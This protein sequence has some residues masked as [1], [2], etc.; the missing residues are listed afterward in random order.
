MPPDEHRE[1]LDDLERLRRRVAELEGAHLQVRLDAAWTDDSYL[2]RALLDYLPDSIYFKDCES[3]FLRINRALADRFG[4]V[5]PADAIGK[6]DA[7]FFSSEHAEQALADEQELLRSGRPMMYKEEKETWPDGRITWVATTKI[8][9]HDEHGELVG[10][11][12]ISRDITRRRRAEEQLRE[13]KAAAEAASRAKSEFLANMSHEIRT[14]MNAIIGMTELVLGTH[15][16]NEQREYLAMVLESG[17]SLLAIINDILD[18]SKVEAGRLELER[19]P[20][21]LRE[22]LGDTMKSLALRAHDQGLE[23]ACEIRSHVPDA[24][25]GDPVRLRQVVVNLVGNAIKF[26][27]RGEVV[28]RVDPHEYAEPSPDEVVLRFTISDTGVGIP[29]E[30]LQAI[31]DAFEQ[32]DS[33]VTRKYGGTG[34]GLAI[35]TRLV[36]LMG[37]VINVRSELD[38]GSTFEFTACFGLAPE[39]IPVPPPERRVIIRGTPVLVVDDNETNRRILNEMLTNWGL[40]PAVA[41]GAATALEMLRQREETG[42]PFRLV[43]TDCHM[44]GIDGFTLVEEIKRLD[45]DKN[46]VVMMLTSGDQ[47]GNIAR[48]EELGVAAYLLKPVKQSELFDAI[49]LAL[50]VT[51]AEDEQ[52]VTHDEVVRLG[53]LT[54]LL[55]EDSLVNQKLALGLLERHGHRVVVASNGK[56]AVGAYA[57]Q[58]F[59]LVLMDVQMPEMDGLEATQA[60]RHIEKQ[61]GRRTPIAAM[62]AHAM[63][64]DRQRCLDAGMD[65]YIA[66]P[67][68]AK[69]LFETIGKLVGERA[70][71]AP[72]LEEG[73]ADSA[74][75]WSEALAA[76]GDDR[77]LLQ[78]L[79]DAFLVESPQR[80]CGIEAAIAARDG[81]DL[82]RQAHSLKSAIQFF[83]VEGAA[84]LACSLEDAGREQN[85]DAASELLS[86]LRVELKELNTGLA[87]RSESM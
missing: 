30:K 54:I 87:A 31:F 49:A 22:S 76:V 1:L 51:G 70:A 69:V 39:E 2:L 3:R 77:E 55:A 8:P 78:E 14:P 56:E 28:V 18:F 35:S 32:A 50:G 67:V 64:G 46:P 33:S 79:I 24:L 62:T 25:L 15:L 7:D 4:L 63:Q 66:K 80:M 74:I 71:V 60:I 75:K 86:L 29:A 45:S 40:R 9:L 41:A 42:D 26:T 73:R 84:D 11:F 17:E 21:S 37:G 43:L 59:D 61:S 6:S 23:L 13:A 12:G 47:P 57:S 44:P 36:A 58:A 20:F 52:Y 38:R 85:F 48:C 10:T 16:T 82:E 81:A 53:P 83:G 34:L 68:R 72:P 19:I 5:D 65:E 27:E